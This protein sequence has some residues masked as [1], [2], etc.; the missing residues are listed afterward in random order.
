MAACRGRGL[1][2]DRPRWTRGRHPRPLKRIFA[3]FGLVRQTATAVIW[4]GPGRAAWP[5]S[6]HAPGRQPHRPPLRPR[7]RPC[8]LRRV[9]LGP[10][11]WSRARPQPGIRDRTVGRALVPRILRVDGFLARRSRL[12]ARRGDEEA[13]H[14]PPNARRAGLL[15][16]PRQTTRRDPSS[17]AAGSER[18]TTSRSALKRR[19][20]SGTWPI[21]SVFARYSNPARAPRPSLGTAAIPRHRTAGIAGSVVFGDRMRS[22]LT[23]IRA[24]GTRRR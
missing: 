9:R 18:A 10:R 24:F 5:V 3:A 13:V 7:R 8:H 20:R 15:G 19:P 6:T 11:H 4:S 21:R 23:T 1:R 22:E 14:H 16:G 17:H 12:C 2:V